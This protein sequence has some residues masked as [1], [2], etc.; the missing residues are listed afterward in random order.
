MD[1]SIVIPAYN[2]EEG[3][4]KVI[5]E[6]KESFSSLSCNYEILIIDDGSTDSTV[7]KAK[8]T[9]VNVIEQYRNQGYG[10]AIM[11]G[12]KNAKYNLI[13]T[14]DA[15]TSYS[16]RDLVK[17]L[18]YIEKFDIVIGKRTGKEFKGKLLKYMARIIFRYLSNYV[19][20]EQIPDINSGLRIFRKSTFLSLPSVHV[21]R[22]FSFST[23]MTLM[24]LAGGYSAQ[25]IPIEYRHRIGNSKIR[26]FRDTIRTLQILFEIAIHYNPLKAILPICFLPFLISVGCLL[27]YF[28]KYNSIWIFCSIISF[29]TSLIIF[30]IGM[31]LFQIRIS[32]K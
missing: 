22:R 15:D 20:G 18:S 9:G 6:I 1:I 13:A 17:L 21:C 11:I 29:S 24:F 4:V 28:L 25:F 5:N 27:I 16:G 19:S 3:I 14:I 10:Q 7:Q 26:H 32:G 2:E 8:E 30:A 12:I 23:T 31:V